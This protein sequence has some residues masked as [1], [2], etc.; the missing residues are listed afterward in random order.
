V[1]SSSNP[2]SPLRLVLA[3]GSA[4]RKVLLERLGIPFTVAIPNVDESRLPG[5]SPVDLV[6]RLARSKAEAVARRHTR[7]LI[8]GS[9]QLAVCGQDVL[10]K[11]G[12]GDRA[13]A[14]LKSLS[15]QRV[16]FNTGIHVINSDTGTNE[17]HI[18]VTTV[19]FRLLTD[20]EI[21]RYVSKDKPYDCAGGFKAEA[22]GISLFERVESIDPTALIGLPLIWL[23]GALR[24]HGFSLP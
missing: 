19:Q 6:H 22:L 4:Y 9:D 7:S 23:A 24:R 12:S 1:S 21:R 10:G 5:E 15:G 8:I 2:A 3:S 14:Q 11:P 18:D 16:T 17:G 20:N 13:I